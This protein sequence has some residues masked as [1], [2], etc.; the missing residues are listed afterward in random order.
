VPLHSE[1]VGKRM[2][3]NIKQMEDK[4]IFQ[5]SNMKDMKKDRDKESC[6]FEHILLLT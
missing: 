6:T 4:R 5:T 1:L 2:L 3:F